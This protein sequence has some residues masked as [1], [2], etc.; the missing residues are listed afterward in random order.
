MFFAIINKL[1]L[2]FNKDEIHLVPAF[3]ALLKD[4]DLGIKAFRFIVACYDYRSP[5]RGLPEAY[6]IKKCAE[7]IYKQKGKVH[8]LDS[9][10]VRFAIEAYNDLQ[11][12][13]DWQEYFAIEEKCTE[14]AKY[15]HETP[16]DPESIDSLDKAGKTLKTYNDIKRDLKEILFARVEKPEGNMNIRAGK[17][18]SFAEEK[19]LPKEL[20]D[21]QTRN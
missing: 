17:K 16:L 4:P 18:L 19:F 15:I 2:D 10:K 20:K 5:Y 8:Q 21:E 1:G 9:D 13:S 3:D 12:D 11:V 7:D 14:I 6:R